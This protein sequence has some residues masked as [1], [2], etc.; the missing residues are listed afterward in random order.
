MGYLQLGARKEG[1]CLQM[2]VREYV[3][4]KALILLWVRAGVDVL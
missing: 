1:D 2:R 4:Y 3:M